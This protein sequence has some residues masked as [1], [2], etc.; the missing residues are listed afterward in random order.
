MA[1]TGA[2]FAFGLPEQVT[3][4][5][6]NAQVTVTTA[7]GQPLPGWLKYI[8]ETKSLV[9]SA[10]PDGAFPMQVI[11]TAGGSRSTIVISEKEQQ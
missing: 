7:S 6:G 8:P 11:V 1:T 10:V 4:A 3:G 9:A 2:G 5:Q